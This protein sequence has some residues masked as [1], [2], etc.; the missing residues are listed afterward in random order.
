MHTSM[1]GKNNHISYL[2]RPIIQRTVI[3]NVI[4]HST[5]QNATHNASQNLCLLSDISNSLV[6]IQEQYINN[7]VNKNYDNIPSFNNYLYLYET[8]TN[9]IQNTTNNSIKLLLMITLG[10]LQ[11]SNQAQILYEENAFLQ[12]SKE[13]L[14]KQLE[15]ILSN[16]NENYAFSTEGQYNLSQDYIL[17]PLFTKYIQTYGLPA[18]G[19]GFDPD[20]LLIIK[21]TM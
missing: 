2:K 12:E 10:S 6:L 19:E 11:T 21:S 16:K 8:I 14:E 3:K 9:E 18:Y 5:N 20:K 7:V 1:F 17:A 4:H 15:D 13:A